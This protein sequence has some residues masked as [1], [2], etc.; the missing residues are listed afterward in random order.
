MR[1]MDDRYKSII[2]YM[3]ILCAF[4]IG[5]LSGY[6]I[7][8]NGT[9]DYVELKEVV[10]Y[11]INDEL[12]EKVILQNITINELTKDLEMWQYM[13]GSMEEKLHDCIEGKINE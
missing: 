12:T 4:S 10:E 11:T 7:S 9:Q 8:S 13:Y 5:I 1:H 3:Y 2:F 6:G